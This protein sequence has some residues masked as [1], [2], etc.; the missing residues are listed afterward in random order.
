MLISIIAQNAATPYNNAAI[1]TSHVTDTFT[2][3]ISWCAQSI[4]PGIAIGTV[5]CGVILVKHFARSST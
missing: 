4:I 3:I 5:I 2:E 1:L